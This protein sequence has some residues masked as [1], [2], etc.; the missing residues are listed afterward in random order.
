[1]SAYKKE[2]ILRYAANQFQQDVPMLKKIAQAGSLAATPNQFYRTVKRETSY[3]ETEWRA[4]ELGRAAFLLLNTMKP[5]EYFAY[6][7]RRRFTRAL[8]A[9][10]AWLT[11]RSDC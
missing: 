9:Q 6:E 1:V 10:P 4:F 3:H 5:Q 2:L 11:I 7:R 8:D